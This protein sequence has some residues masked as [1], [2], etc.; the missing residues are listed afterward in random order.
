MSRYVLPRATRICVVVL[1][2]AALFVGQS[3]QAAEGDAQKKK[4]DR[5]LERTRDTVKMLDDV[6]KTAVV[7]IT[8]HYVNDDD[9]LP[10]GTA[11][12]ELGDESIMGDLVVVIARAR[13]G[14]LDGA[15]ESLATLDMR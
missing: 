14:D 2:L 12:I 6:Y 10:A 15:R 4:K 1:A 13:L 7:L 9:D 3:I 11:A 8:T 5:A